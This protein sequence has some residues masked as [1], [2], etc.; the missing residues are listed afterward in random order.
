MSNTAGMDVGQG[1]FSI[2]GW[3]KTSSTQDFS[4]LASLDFWSPALYLR[5]GLQGKL[6][7]Y[8]NGVGGFTASTA[9]SFNDGAWHHFAVTRKTAQ[10]TYYKDGVESGFAGIYKTGLFPQKFVIG[11]DKS[12]GADY[13]NGALDE[14]DFFSRALTDVEIQ[15]IYN[16]GSSG[17]CVT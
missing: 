17:K 10:I 15:S 6:Q 7:F 16:A 1:D 8:Q 14:V 5:G 4:T 12:T 13:L 2:D 9:G 11:W 3:V